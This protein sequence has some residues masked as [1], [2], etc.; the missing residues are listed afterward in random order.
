MKCEKSMRFVEADMA[1]QRVA[2]L[3]KIEKEKVIQSRKTDHEETV[4]III[5]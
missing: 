4:T 5:Y 1:K 3:R 2:Q